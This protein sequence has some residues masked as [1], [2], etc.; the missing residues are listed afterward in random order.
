MSD[1][2]IPVKV[3]TIEYYGSGCLK[4][5]SETRKVCG[6]LIRPDQISSRQPYQTMIKWEPW[7]MDLDFKTKKTAC[8]S[9]DHDNMSCNPV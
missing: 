2:L 6:Y 7:K 1:L 5:V 8:K 9:R 3:S 4:L